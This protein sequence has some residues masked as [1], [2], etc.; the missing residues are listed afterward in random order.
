MMAKNI[1]NQVHSNNKE[2]FKIIKEYLNKI[3]NK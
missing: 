2:I 1:K 3:N